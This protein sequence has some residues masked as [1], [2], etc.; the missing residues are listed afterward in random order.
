M[1]ERKVY[2][3][4]CT[5]VLTNEPAWLKGFRKQYDKPFDLHITLKQMAYINESDLT[6]I[7]H[8]LEECLSALGKVK[9][10][11]Q[12]EFDRLVRE[13]SDP[14]SGTGMLYVFA[15]KRNSILDQLQLRI[16]KSLAIYS[17]YYFK[18]SSRYESDFQPHITIARD[19]DEQTLEAAIHELPYNVRMVGTIDSVVLSC[20]DESRVG[21]HPRHEELTTFDLRQS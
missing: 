10:P 5:V 18:E 6:D 16:R 17:D 3:I 11:L 12:L 4:Y 1:S 7:R 13:S 2:A 8:T 14:D 21:Q 20:L 9:E 19:L 15:T